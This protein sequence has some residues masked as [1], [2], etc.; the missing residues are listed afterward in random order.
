MRYYIYTILLCLFAT[1]CND[2]VQKWDNWPEWKMPSSLYVGGEVLDEEV[3]SDFLGKKLHLE[4]GQE[5]EFVGVDG[6]ESILPPDYFEYLSGN[7]ARFKGRT[8]DYTVLYDPSSELLYIEKEDA[9]YPDGLWLCGANWGHPQA[10]VV[11]TDGWSMDGANNVLYCFKKADNVF[12]LTLYLANNFSF[13]FFKHRG[14]GEGD[15]EITTFPED[16]VTLL[17]PFLVAG[18]ATGDFVPGPLFQPGV[19]LITLD[20]NSN[21]CAFEARDESI[22]SESFRVNGQEMGILSE[23]ASY[24]GVVLEL[25]KGEE[26]TF[27]NFEDVR[28]MLQPDFFEGISANKAKFLGEDG[29]YKL[30]YDPL[31][32]LM[33]LENRSIGYPDCL[34]VCGESFGHPKAGRVTVNTWTFNAP[35]DAF[36]CVKIADDIFETTL[37]LVKDFKFK[38]YRQH[39][40]GGE[41]GST[42]VNPYPV[43]LLGKGW[44]YSDPVTGG[45]GGGHFTGDF[46]AGPNFVPGVYRVRIDL[47]KNVCMFA[48][49]AE[50]GQIQPESYKI[51]GRELVQSSYTNYIGVE[52]DLIKGQ[53]V[54]FEGFTYLDYMLQP[55]YFIKENGQYR[56]NASDGKYKILYNKDRELM[57]VEVADVSLAYPDVLWVCGLRLGHPRISGLLIEDIAGNLNNGN[58]LWD[59]PK[60]AICCIKTGERVFETTLLLQKD[61]MF[62]FFKQRGVWNDVITSFEVNI[63]SEGDLIGR[64]GYWEENQWKETENF[65]PGGNFIPGVYHVKL[66]MNTKRCT[67]MKK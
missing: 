56:F 34:W 61:F 47:N 50:E 48:D 35:S 15:N 44:Y 36:Q 66:D 5:V 41:L 22:Q 37:Y 31:N 29:D 40:W 39:S 57:F 21:T 42:I 62:K 27:E 33:Y 64:G 67:F 17:T 45:T 4:K 51:N 49:K 7:K 26:V 55:E 58:W 16:N 54:D 12:Q 23:A 46:V 10:G 6:V 1:A 52:L 28:K 63:V 19:Y 14:W 9:V 20:L 11:T 24:L 18:K 8:D 32:K 65:G 38:F 43:N 53:I 25:Q 2:D 60:D 30:F 3:Y 13:K 59:A